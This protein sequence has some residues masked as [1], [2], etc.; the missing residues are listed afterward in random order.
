MLGPSLSSYF[1]LH[2]VFLFSVEKTGIKQLV[3]GH[4]ARKERSQAWEPSLPGLQPQQE[5]GELLQLHIHLVVRNLWAHSMGPACP[6]AE[7]KPSKRRMALED[8]W[9]GS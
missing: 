5:P 2:K 1:I 9:S 7:N 4:M 8:A 6:W 3:Q